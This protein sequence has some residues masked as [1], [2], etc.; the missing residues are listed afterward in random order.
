MDAAPHPYQPIIA[1]PAA[2]A[3]AALTP[4][5]ISFIRA[6]PKAELHAHLNGSIP[7]ATLRELA[8]AHP[9]L[10]TDPAVQAGLAK[11]E[12]GVQ[13]AELHDFFGL[14]PAIYALTSTPAALQAA[15]RAVLASF[16]TPGLDGAA[17]C[18]YLELRTGPRATE[19]M[20]RREYLEAVLD[21]V[22]AYPPEQAALIVALDRPM[23]DEH[24]SEVVALAVA[25]KAE[26][27]RVMGIDLCGSPVG[28]DVAKLCA[29]IREAKAAGLKVTLHV[30]EVYIHPLLSSRGCVLMRLSSHQ[31]YGAAGR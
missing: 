7:F 30:A 25:L 8:R 28:G 12:G 3:L 16:L 1:G 4:A 14:F 24:M 26:G 21:A 13:L 23:P 9:T 20:S 19:Y 6:L 18:A 2:A 11:L 29:R 5:Q 27:R 22:E 31:G 15:T 10:S 17:E